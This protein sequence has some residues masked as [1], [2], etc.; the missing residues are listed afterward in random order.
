[1][2][3][4]RNEEN[5]NSNPF[6]RFSQ[7]ARLAFAAAD[8]ISRNVGAN[9]VGSEHLLLGI[10]ENQTSIASSILAMMGIDR[11]VIGNF[12][13]IKK[14]TATKSNVALRGISDDLKAI[15]AAAIKISFQFHHNFIGTEHLLLAISE[16][17]DCAAAQILE[18]IAVSLLD[19][20]KKT[21][22]V[23]VKISESK[24]NTPPPQILEDLIGGLQSALF[25]M[26]DGDKGFKKVKTEKM[27]PADPFDKNEPES[28][29]PALDFFATDLNAECQEGKLDPI[30][31]REEEIQRMIN[32][33]CRKT[34]N[35]PLLIGEP[36][37]GKTAI[38]E[39]LAQAIE[40]GAV[41]EQLLN[42]R[43][44]SLSLTN[45]IAGTKFR[46]EFEDR[47][48]EI[49]DEATETDNE[50]ILFVDELHTIIGA[51][52]AEGSLDAANI[53]K[54]PLSRGKIRLIGATTFD[55][56]RK[57][58]EK[59]RAL[60][61]RFQTISVDEPNAKDAET[62]L[63]GLRKNF[64]E[65]HNLEISNAAVKSAVQLSQRYI[66]DKFLP[67]KAIDILDEA[68]AQKSA[69]IDA[70]NNDIKNL[71]E[72][73]H[74]IFKKKEAAVRSQNFKKALELKREEEKI[75]DEIQKIKK[76]NSK[77]K[78]REKID[79]NDIF[80]IIAQITK[81]PLQKLEKSE[82][83]RLLNLEEKLGEK[84]VGQTEALR[85]ISR[86]IRRN[87]AGVGDEKRPIGTFLF[88]GPTG[89]GKT[90]TVR[91][92][93]EEIFQTEDSLVKIDMS[94]FA[95]R[96]SASRLTGTTAGYVGFE[97]G[98]ELTEKIRR[99]PF[100]V[101][102]F[103]EIEKAHRDFQN[104]LLQILEDGILTDGKGRKV[105]FKNTI[106]ILTSNIGGETL[107]DEAV[108]IGFSKT[109]NE[110]KKLDEEFAEKKEMVLEKV[111][112]HF[113]PEFLNR[114]DKIVVFDPLKKAEI[115]KIVK[116]NLKNFAKRL[117]AKK[118]KTEFSENLI[119]FLASKSFDPKNGARLVRR[120]ISER[121]EN[122]VAEEILRGGIAEN[123]AI[124]IDAEKSKI[125]IRV[126]TT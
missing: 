50:I 53:L 78:K 69:K 81:I 13:K 18:N 40:R 94:E 29:T 97:E 34:K 113:R 99:K 93:A 70:E 10:L 90:E 63:L 109:K 111:R 16:H 15:I 72:K 119:D 87:R 107:T 43:V 80:K 67:D 105:N 12:L 51:G 114:L 21:K 3:N 60:E 22:N 33:L 45:L 66:F 64:E 26:R 19:L 24:S 125:K 46:G 82:I 117:A 9:F 92:L 17:P 104:T 4:P 54:P 126:K 7:D 83:E 59:D 23:L 48:K 91:V 11:K 52:S 88:L 36:G 47:L 122:A 57:H 42:K 68:A 106:V 101:V 65:F 37:V 25:G 5:K 100:S 116:L 49:I 102:L 110:E 103:D 32:I 35:N 98:G 120:E 62:I 58:I 73:I 44:L 95:E 123:S 39:G 28:E 118:I 124:E 112:K 30:I 77:N 85:E 96:H 75:E 14:S 89:V 71:R 108:K 115:R 27:N 61:R 84:I 31:G 6:D 56:H 41:P 38:A 55:E 86:A 8:E 20:Q 1:M 121:V 2:K 74:K 79:E 76:E